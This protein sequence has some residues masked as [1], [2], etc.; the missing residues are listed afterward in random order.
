MRHKMDSTATITQ[1]DADLPRSEAVF[2]A[3]RDDI[4]NSRIAT[5][6]KLFE[7]TVAERYEASRTPVREALQRLAA[8]GLLI[9]RGRAYLPPVIDY[10]FVDNLYSVREAL[11][12]K[13]MELFVARRTSLAETRGPLMAMES[14][15]TVSDHEAFN[16]ADIA[17][18]AALAR[19]T[20]NDILES[21]LTTVWD[22]VIYVRNAVFRDPLRLQ[23]S[24]QE[25]RRI[26]Q[27]L[28]RGNDVI[29]VEEMRAHLRSVPELLK[30]KL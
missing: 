25:H 15:I 5:D 26:V 20:G 28:E 30:R 21:L 29:A 16:V 11:E 4:L 3:L 9:R 22:R 23:A 13:G 8:D 10:D 6:E 1:D 2:R 7:S 17:F 14:A 27:A 12:C 24:L 18:H 19:G